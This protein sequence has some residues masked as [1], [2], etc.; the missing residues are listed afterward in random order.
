MTAEAKAEL[1]EKI[2]AGTFRIA[3]QAQA[4]LKEKNHIE[5][6]TNSFY[7]QLG[8]FGGW[9]RVARPSRLKSV[10]KA[11]SAFKVTLAKKM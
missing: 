5:F 2:G 9:Y 10:E 11:A 6:D 4:W 8:K 7:Y 1:T 3:D